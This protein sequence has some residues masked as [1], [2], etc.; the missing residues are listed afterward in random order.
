M[1]T[2]DEPAAQAVQALLPSKPA[3]SAPAGQLTHDVEPALAPRLAKVLTGHA[4]QLSPVPRVIRPGGHGWHK[5]EALA[6]RADVKVP[7]GQRV[8]VLAPGAVL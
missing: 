4:K 2:V 5:V 6:P 7:T 1:P 8:H 3:V